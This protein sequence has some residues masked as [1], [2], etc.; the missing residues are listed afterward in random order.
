M[1]PYQ[2]QYVENLKQIAEL[3]AISP[4]LPGDIHDFIKKRQENMTRSQ[5]L[6]KENT[7]LL[8]R[9]LMPLLDDIVSASQEEIADLE[10][11][12]GHLLSGVNQ[13]DVFL[14]YIIRNALVTYARKWGLRDMLIREL[15][16]TGLALFYLQDRLVAAH[17]STYRWKMNMMFGEA[18]SYIKKYDEIEN[19][20]I[21]GYIHRSM[22]NLGL[23]YGWGSEEEVGKKMDVFRRCLDIMTD[24]VYRAKTP[25]LPWDRY[26]YNI[27]QIRSSGT[28]YLKIAGSEADPR[29]QREIMES[30]Q[31][32]WEHQLDTSREKGVEITSRW[33]LK[34]EVTQYHCGIRTLS[35]LLTQIEKY[36]MGRN[37]SDYTE[38]G[39][40]NNLYL[41]SLYGEYLLTDEEMKYKKKRIIGYM[42]RSIVKYVR[43]MPGNQLDAKMLRNLVLVMDRFVEYPGSITL[44][45]FLLELVV[46]RNPDA[47]VNLYLTAEISLMLARKALEKDPRVFL[48][49]MGCGTVEELREKK[50]DLLRLVYESGMLYDVGY[51]NVSTMVSQTGRSWFGEERKMYESHVNSGQYILSKC[52]S[53]RPYMDVAY[54]HHRYY[55]GKGGYPED[56][57]R[58]NKPNQPV[59][60]LIS[61][62]SFLVRNIHEKQITIHRVLSLEKILEKIEE[63]SG[64]RFSPEF[65]GLL[66]GMESELREYLQDGVEKA[67]QASFRLLQG[68]LT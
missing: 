51:L 8:R 20:E 1:R 4:E 62:V 18:A 60:D 31:F 13:L 10:D 44:K 46:C 23:S 27:H 24:P 16:H 33:V 42:Y 58:E 65:A 32:L 9:E 7:E 56:Y 3:S 39:I 15:Y 11:F 53:T 45:D 67:Y 61:V 21:R 30:S 40:E 48:G 57:V 50:E 63:G 36:Y 29:I 49:T 34:N 12:A 47:Y 14:D 38:A 25:S 37:P 68:K 41:P 17:L 66:C 54:G 5:E 28:S 59:I 52:D 2:K 35:H 6:V 64:S 43:S 22:A 26:V 55:D 19:V